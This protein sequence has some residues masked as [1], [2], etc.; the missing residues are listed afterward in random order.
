[1]WG[2][3]FDVTSTPQ[4]PP[5]RSTSIGDNQ[6]EP[7]TPKMQG[8]IISYKMIPRVLI[9]M[10]PRKIITTIHNHVRPLDVLVQTFGN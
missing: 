7:K 6:T 9:I 4:I 1:M 3:N 5:N 10:T 8:K 2:G